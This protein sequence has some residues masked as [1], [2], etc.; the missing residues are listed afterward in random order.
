MT[1]TPPLAPIVRGVDTRELIPGIA[2][3]TQNSTVIEATGD[4]VDELEMA[5]QS[6]EY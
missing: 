6:P 4:A 2:C 5:G 3:L 1:Q